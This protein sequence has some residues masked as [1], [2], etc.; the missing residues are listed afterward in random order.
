MI[1]KKIEEVKFGITTSERDCCHHC[2]KNLEGRKGFVRIK[3]NYSGNFRGYKYIFICRECFDKM[4]KSYEKDKKKSSKMYDER[5]KK[6]ML[7][8]LNKGNPKEEGK[9]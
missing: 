6:R 8:E 9:S 5:V 7:I 4:V 2:Y 3:I 1:L